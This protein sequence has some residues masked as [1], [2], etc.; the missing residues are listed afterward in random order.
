MATLNDTPYF[1]PLDN[2]SYEET[3]YFLFGVDIEEKEEKE[4]KE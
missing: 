3:A 2:M 4:E 1:P